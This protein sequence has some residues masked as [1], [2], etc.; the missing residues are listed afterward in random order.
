MTYTYSGKHPYNINEVSGITGSPALRIKCNNGRRYTVTP[1][2]C[3][4]IMP[5]CG[6]CATKYSGIASLDAGREA[7]LDAE[8]RTDLYVMIPLDALEYA[9]HIHG[10]LSGADFL[11][12]WRSESNLRPMS[13]EWALGVTRCLRQLGT[14][15]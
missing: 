15:D 4:G 8:S 14:E 3:K 2:A 5:K 9:Q 11:E 7:K 12:A 6:E 10:L 1:A 13:S